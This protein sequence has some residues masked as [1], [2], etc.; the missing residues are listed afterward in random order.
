MIRKPMKVE[1]LFINSDPEDGGDVDHVLSGR[2]RFVLVAYP[3]AQE[4]Q[5][6]KGKKG[7]KKILSH[8]TSVLLELP[9]DG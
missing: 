6:E 3:S 8:K 4:E 5:G 9:A 7:K 2:H 1:K